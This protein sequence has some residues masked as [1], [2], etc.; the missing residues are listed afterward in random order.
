M[1]S[2]QAKRQATRYV[3]D[4]WHYSERQACRVVNTGR[5][6][7]RYQQRQK[8]DE[9]VLRR[10]IRELAD[11]HKSY[12]YRFITA[13]LR[14]EGFLVNK[15]RVYRIWQ[16]EGLQ[17]TRRRVAKRRY[18]PAGETLQRA[19]RR[20]HVWSYDFI[21]D[22]TESGNKIRI[23][24]VVDEFT[25]ECL[26]IRADR[27]IPATKV[28]DT[29]E[30]LQLLHGAPEHIRSDNGPEF[31]AH[32]V[33]EWLEQRDCNTIYITPGS[34][35]ENP[36]IESFFATLRRECLNRNLF[37]SGAEAQTVL[38]EWRQ[39]YNR[40]RPHSSLEYMTPEAYANTCTTMSIAK[41]LPAAIAT[42]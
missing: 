16:E 9:T 8:P 35:W 1:V 22:R 39:E 2:P 20:N 7:V 36:F 40:Y 5:S 3:E 18:G 24:G 30:W 34:P 21:E 31:I 11:K 38:E 33:Q 41:T 6:S 4:A 10:R 13:L 27:S 15:K 42:G 12:G 26:S 37:Y 17:Q 28:I 14:R 29:L 23:L 25:R 32:A 19:E